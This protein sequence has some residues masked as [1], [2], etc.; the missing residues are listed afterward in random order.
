MKAQLLF[1]NIELGLDAIYGYHAAMV[2]MT[3]DN[4]DFPFQFHELSII[5]D[6][7]I[8]TGYD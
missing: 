2:L 6:V 5:C 1:I 4:F 7:T 8:N 3:I